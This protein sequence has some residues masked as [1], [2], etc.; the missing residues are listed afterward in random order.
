MSS[1]RNHLKGLSNLFGTTFWFSPLIVGEKHCN[2]IC[3][4]APTCQLDWWTILQRKI[5][6]MTD[7]TKQGNLNW[8]LPHSALSWN[9]SWAENLESLSLQDGA[10]KWHYFLKEPTSQPPGL[11]SFKLNNHSIHWSYL[12]KIVN[13][14]LYD[15]TMLC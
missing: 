3:F 13:L 4:S 15:Q 2:L 6:G 14:S 12:T 7:F 11:L 1:N 8:K 9:F 5:S 10:M